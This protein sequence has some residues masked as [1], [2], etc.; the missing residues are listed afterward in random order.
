MSAERLIERLETIEKLNERV[1]PFRLLASAE[2]DILRDGTLD[3]PD[4]VLSRLDI[5][6]V[7]IHSGFK[8]DREQMTER[9]DESPEESP[10]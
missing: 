5:V 7:S 2:V 6:V 3:Y 8:M 1:A 10:C 4:E 9:V